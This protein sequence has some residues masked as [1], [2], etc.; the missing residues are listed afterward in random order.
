MLAKKKYYSWGG[1][2]VH[3]AKKTALGGVSCR[4]HSPSSSTCPMADSTYDVNWPHTRPPRMQEV[5][6]SS[7]AWLWG[8]ML[9]IELW[10]G[11]A[12]SI[13]LAFLATPCDA[14]EE[15]WPLCSE[16]EVT[17]GNRWTSEAVQKHAMFGTTKLLPSGCS[18]ADCCDPSSAS[19]ST[20]ISL[21]PHHVQV[22]DENPGNLLHHVPVPAA[23][24]IYQGRVTSASRSPARADT[25]TV[26]P[27]PLVLDPHNPGALLGISS[28]GPA[29]AVAVTSRLTRAR[30][31]RACVGAKACDAR[32]DTMRWCCETPGCGAPDLSS[33]PP[34]AAGFVG[35]WKQQRTENYIQYL[36]EVNCHDT[37]DRNM[38]FFW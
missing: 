26:A 28:P 8:L 24:A 15:P 20:P 30:N 29:R 31:I 7:E 6:R 3:P 11:A 10:L 19:T 13:L 34:C 32:A 35:T 18:A 25:N 2:L 4:V 37:L 14:H 27:L 23:S 38:A 33:L 5:S 16:P 12:A 22:L 1:Q 21:Q 17:V 9:G 36:H